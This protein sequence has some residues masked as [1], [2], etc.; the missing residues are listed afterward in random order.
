MM[1]DRVKELGAI[2]MI[3]DGV[4]GA[5]APRRH[6]RLWLDGPRPYRNAMKPFVRNPELTRLL[7][8]AQVALGVWWASRQWPRPTVD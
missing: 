7:S 3:G 8:V 4:V 1:G 2:L 5:L 6:T